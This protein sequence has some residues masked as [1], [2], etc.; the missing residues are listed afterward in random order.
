MA[1][2]TIPVRVL[3]PHVKRHIQ[4]AVDALDLVLTEGLLCPGDRD[5]IVEAGNAA[6]AAT[7]DLDRMARS[8]EE[9]HL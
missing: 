6:V 3:I 8:L 2:P 9:G 7:V 5:R 4:H 1:T